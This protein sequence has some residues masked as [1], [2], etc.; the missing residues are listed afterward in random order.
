M[1]LSETAI[2]WNSLRGFYVTKGIYLRSF[3]PHPSILASKSSNMFQRTFID[4]LWKHMNIRSNNEVSL[5][6]F[7]NFLCVVFRLEPFGAGILG[8]NACAIVYVNLS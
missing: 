7:N 3:S 1:Y 6:L 4:L 8:N 2:K 5:L